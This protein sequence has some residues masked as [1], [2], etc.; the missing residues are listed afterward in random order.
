[1]KG[2][3]KTIKGVGLEMI[4]IPMPECK[5]HEVLIKI[6]KSAICGTDVSIYK[7][8]PWA[9]KTIPVPMVIG[10]EFMG[11]VHAAGSKVRGIAVGDRVSGEGHITCGF[12]RN[13]LEGNR[14]LCPATKGVGVNRQ[15]CFAEYLV[16]PAENVFRIPDDVSDELASVMD[17]LGNATFTALSYEL[18]GE[19]VL[20]TGAGP[21]GCMAAAI[22]QFAGAKEIIVTDPNPYRLE[23]AKKMGASITINVSEKEATETLKNLFLSEKI[24]VGLE[25]SGYPDGL[26]T[27]ID[28]VEM[29]GGI[30][31]LGLLP[32]N[33]LIDWD[34]VIFKTLTLKGIY[35]RKIFGTWFKMIGMLQG[36]LNIQPIFTHQFKADDFQKGFDAMLS[37]QSGKVILD[38]E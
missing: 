1:M 35:G 5:D 18:I 16:I 3:A 34:K 13:C 36:G 10:H 12:C 23:L 4:D 21:I 9:E 15:G 31:L 2:I 33:T 37:G 17:P 14:H 8:T 19:N 7:W 28:N 11:I 22:C 26:R 6:K 25:M 38:W 27:L 24:R 29:G 30:S 20:I 32:S